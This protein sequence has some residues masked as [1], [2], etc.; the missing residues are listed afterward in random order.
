MFGEIHMLVTE[1]LQD[2]VP[3]QEIA[4]AIAMDFDVDEDFAYNL[5]DEIVAELDL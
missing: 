2:G 5:I 3:D 1:M 4:R